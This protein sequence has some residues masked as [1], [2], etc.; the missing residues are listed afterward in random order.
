V[1]RPFDRPPQRSHREPLSLREG[2]AAD[3]WKG[4]SGWSVEGD[5]EEYISCV[6]RSA[7]SDGLQHRFTIG[8]RPTE[9]EKTIWRKRITRCLFRQPVPSRHLSNKPARATRLCISI[10][11]DWNSLPQRRDSHMTTVATLTCNALA[12]SDRCVAVP[13]PF[14]L[15]G[16]Y[17][18]SQ[19]ASPFGQVLQPSLWIGV[20]P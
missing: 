2:K 11:G 13:N 8:R 9:L 4:R 15:S 18:I 16:H 17:L 6:S 1:A 3:V 12:C 5:Q 20:F 14:V 19:G 7:G 10:T